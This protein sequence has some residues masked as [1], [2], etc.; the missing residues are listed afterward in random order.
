MKVY[1]ASTTDKALIMPYDPGAGLYS[2]NIGFID[3]KFQPER[4]AEIHE[5]KGYLEFEALI[6][7]LNDRN[8]IFRT[9]RVDTG[10]NQPSHC[11]PEFPSSCYAYLTFTFDTPENWSN[12]ELYQGLKFELGENLTR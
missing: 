9:F 12:K 10:L 1:T 6:R 5:L 3:L 2:P 8:S 7:Q 11:S 4:I